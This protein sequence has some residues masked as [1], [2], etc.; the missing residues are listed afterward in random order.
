MAY[1]AG[2]RGVRALPEGVARAGVRPRRRARAPAATARGIHRL[3]RNLRRVLAHTRPASDDG[4]DDL[5]AAAMRS[6]ARYWRETFRLP[7]MDKAE[8]ARAARAADTDG[9][10]A[11]RRRRGPGP[12]RDPRPAAQRQLG[13]RRRSGWSRTG[14]RSPPSPSGCKPESLF[15][16][17]VA[18]RESLGMEVLPLSGGAQPPADVLGDRLRAGRAIC[19]LADRDMS[20]HGVPVEFF[21]AAATMPPGPALLAARTGAALLPV[22]LSFTGT[23]SRDEGWRQW[24]GPPVDLGP[25]DDT[26]TDRVARGTQALATAFEQRIG[27]RPEDWHMLA[28]LWTADRAADRAARRPGDRVPDGSGPPRPGPT[29]EP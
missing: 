10:G 14:C 22:H 12:R 28:T 7:G 16:R 23:G 1:A 24:I 6:Y 5:V 8:V 26:L 21:G 19:L 4:L 27:Q 2:W 9:V 13:R 18:Y 25:D 29:M 3:R 17:F 20:R 15:D 11:H